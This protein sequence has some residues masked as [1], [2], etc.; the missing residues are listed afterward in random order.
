MLP[1]K[2][3]SNA[4][5]RR[6]STWRHRQQ[7]SRRMV[8]K[9]ILLSALVVIALMTSSMD[10][11]NIKPS[12]AQTSP[13]LKD[14]PSTLPEI[15]PT[16]SSSISS[17]EIA[18][19]QIKDSIHSSS[20]S[21]LDFEPFGN[22]TASSQAHSIFNC[23]SSHGL[24][25]WYYP[26]KFFH[27]Q[28]GLGKEYI[29]WLQ[30]MEEQR[31]AKTLWPGG[32]PPIVL[33]WASLS[34]DLKPNFRSE[35]FPRH[36]L[37]MIHVHKTGGTSMVLAFDELKRLGAPM[38]RYISYL[39][40]MPE[41]KATQAYER[42]SQLLQGTVRYQDTWGRKDHTLMAVI[43][44]PAQRFI[45][46][47]G[48]AMGGQGSNT[49]IASELRQTC[50]KKTARETLQ[51]CVDKIQKEGFWFEVHFTPMALEISFASLF[52]DIPIAVFPFSAVPKI[53]Y[54]LDQ[55]PSLKRKDGSF[56]GFRKDP[57]LTNMSM[58]DYDETTLRELCDLYRVDTL[59]LQYLGHRST[60][61]RYT[62]I[63]FNK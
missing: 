46:A 35:P 15:T 24:C 22:R 8:Y 61:D 30:H 56:P 9:C 36:N 26:A 42:S 34:P 29:N 28:C 17:E 54:E 2:Y 23:G 14:T 18:F 60:C 44:D 43:R 16:T 51:C 47:I 31:M 62:P 37:S 21:C 4:I 48:Q 49:R 5:H 45:S 58:E 27:P 38:E 52:K 7:Q 32:M 59:F 63:I 10:L 39:Q 13:S 25:T 1:R 19:Q 40:S 12:H 41:P 57:I 6:F 53:M 20:P 11:Y 50:L 55:D 33:P 3:L